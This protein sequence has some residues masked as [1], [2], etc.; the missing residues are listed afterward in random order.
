MYP[1]HKETL[2]L[3]M[4]VLVTNYQTHLPDLFLSWLDNIVAVTKTGNI[5]SI[6]SADA[7]FCFNMQLQNS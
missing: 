1:V 2:F 3:W 7:Q 5:S 4:L 6:N